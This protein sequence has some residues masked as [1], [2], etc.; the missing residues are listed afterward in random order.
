MIDCPNCGAAVS[1]P[2]DPYSAAEE[3]HEID[4]ESCGAELVAEL[5][6]YWSV[7]QR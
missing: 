7:E 4:C 1:E 6:C 3:H 2:E 5:I